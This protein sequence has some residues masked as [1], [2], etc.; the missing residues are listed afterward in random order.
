VLLVVLLPPLPAD[1]ATRRRALLTRALPRFSATALVAWGVLGLTGLYSAWLQVGSLAALRATDYGVTLVVKLALL[2][3]L[4]ALGAVNLLAASPGIR[5]EAMTARTAGTWVRRLPWTIGAEVALVTVVLLVVGRLT[6]LEPARAEFAAQQPADVVVPLVLD[7]DETARPAT[8]TI[9]PGAAGP[10]RYRL[11][12]AGDAVP[13]GGETLLRVSLPALGVGAQEIALT[14]AGPSVFTGGGSEL[15]IAGVWTVETVVRKIGAFSWDATQTVALGAT[16]PATAPP[17][18]TWVFGDRGLPALA[19]VAAGLV[20]AVVAWRRPSRRPGW[21]GVA[22]AAL[23]AGAIVLLQ[24]RI[25]PAAPA[26]AVSMIAATPAA[27]P[28]AAPQTVGVLARAPST[29]PTAPLPAA[30]AGTPVTHDGLTVTLLPTPRQTGATTVTATIAD[31]SGAPVKDATVTAIVRSLAMDMGTQ[32]AAARETAP[33]RYAAADVPLSMSGQWRL[34][35]RVAPRG[36]PSTSFVYDL[37][38]SSAGA[39]P[40]AG[41]QGG[42]NG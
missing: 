12:I 36:Q 40:R 22:A 18:P 27:T 10:N 2:V 42:A 17:T 41:E 1:G 30:A 35:I 28:V 37:D 8:L 23:A 16:P 38:V 29:A 21:S 14:R 32:S 31:A 7:P 6:S 15:G 9:A 11:D 24:A 20:A 25:V 5:R 3:P 26:E 33:G 4:L 39:T 13:P 19:L 34:T